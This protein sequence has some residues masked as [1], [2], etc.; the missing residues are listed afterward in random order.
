MP[1][2][3]PPTLMPPPPSNT[4][5][6]PAYFQASSLNMNA[7]TGLTPEMAAKVSVE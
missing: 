1:S 7:L 3:I 2:M 4:A 6:L 5:D